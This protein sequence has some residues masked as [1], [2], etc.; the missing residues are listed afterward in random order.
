VKVGIVYPIPFGEDGSIGGGER[1]A[2]ELAKAMAEV[3]DTVL[4]T[5]GRDRK[6]ET[7]GRLRIE[8]H[9]WWTLVRGLR[10]N[11][12]SVGFLRSLGNVDVVHCLS[13][14]TLL[15]DA[16]VLF[17]RLTRKKS[18]IT[19][20][21][22]GGNLTLAR[23]VNIARL[24]TGLLLLSEFASHTFSH[25]SSMRYVIYGGV[26]DL[27]F[28][29]AHGRRS[30]KV[31]YVGRLLRH[32]G[33]NY[34]IDALEPALPLV[35]AGR[36]YDPAYFEH[37]RSLAAGKDVTF[38]TNATD[39][40]IIAEYRSSAVFVIP[41]VYEDVYGNRTAAPELLGLSALEAM[42]CGLPVICTDVGSLPELVEDGVTGFVVPP[43]NPAALANR[44]ALLVNDLDRA[45]E[46]G[47]RAR[48][49]VEERFTW[50]RVVDRC[51]QVY[52]QA[53]A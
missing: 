10:Q 29:P 47:A 9:P 36:A 11:P 43:N 41:S 24:S 31:L 46:M 15:T 4:V 17:A 12:L 16:S 26:D 18:F 32:K 44:I 7:I 33:V 52:Q 45:T 19:D 8:T 25:N 3:V 30:R 28:N 48:A 42:A 1:Y 35:I 38:L 53:G 23:W 6:R 27:R 39:H 5:I 13:Y 50:R 34:L 2:L 51:L 22:G 21:G 49:V 20:V 40:E 37:L 14:N